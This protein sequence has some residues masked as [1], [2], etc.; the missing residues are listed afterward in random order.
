[1]REKILSQVTSKI[2]DA[3]MV[4]KYTLSSL[5][6]FF[7]STFNQQRWLLDPFKFGLKERKTGKVDDNSKDFTITCVQAIGFL[8]KMTFKK[9]VRKG[10]E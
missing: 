5:L 7:G 3:A 4:K 1:M 6:S 2:G 10:F 8:F 9:H